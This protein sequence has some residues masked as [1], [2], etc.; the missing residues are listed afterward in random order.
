[1]QRNT[2]RH[3]KKQGLDLPIPNPACIVNSSCYF[4]KTFLKIKRCVTLLIGGFKNFNRWSDFC[5]G[6]HTLNWFICPRNF[7]LHQRILHLKLEY[8]QN[9]SSIL[10]ID[11]SSCRILQNSLLKESYHYMLNSLIVIR[12]QE[13][14]L[15][16]GFI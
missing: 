6:F 11:Y 5:A 14:L 12:S 3:L 8:Y 10:R 1:M 2:L 16:S 15:C 7:S 9:W 13:Y 4:L